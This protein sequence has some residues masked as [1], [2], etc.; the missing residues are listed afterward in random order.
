MQL[1]SDEKSAGSGD[2]STLSIICQFYSTC[3]EAELDL[4]KIRKKGEAN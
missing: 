2:G 3:V 4:A 1:T